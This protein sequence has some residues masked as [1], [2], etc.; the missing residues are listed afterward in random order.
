MYDSIVWT[1]YKH[2]Q[3]FPLARAHTHAHT[4][5][6]HLSTL[7]WLFSSPC[8]SPSVL[9]SPN[10]YTICY[11]EEEEEEEGTKVDVLSFFFKKNILTF[12][13]WHLVSPVYENSMCYLWLVGDWVA[14]AER[15]LLLW[16]YSGIAS[17]AC[18]G[19]TYRATPGKRAGAPTQRAV[20]CSEVTLRP[21]LAL[22]SFQGFLPRLY[23][24]CKW[25]WTY[26][27]LNS[28]IFIWQ[29]LAHIGKPSQIFKILAG[30]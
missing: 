17:T 7:L 25:H 11:W 8:T 12:W 13:S 9:Q 3:S 15:P 1:Y 18:T 23:W 21:R 28:F 27:T 22:V 19:M 30:F 4:T 26:L 24:D 2:N 29:Q 10:H 20:N 14:S 6:A 5:H 16:K